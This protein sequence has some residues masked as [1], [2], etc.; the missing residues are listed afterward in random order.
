MTTATS[1]LEEERDITRHYTAEERGIIYEA[2]M[3][4]MENGDREE[5]DRLRAM[6]PLHPRWAKIAAEVKGKAYLLKHFNITH[7]NEVYGEGWLDAIKD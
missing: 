7:A 5:A 1:I 4:A 6:L 2:C 3:V